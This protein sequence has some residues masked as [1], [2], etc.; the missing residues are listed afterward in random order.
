MTNGSKLRAVERRKK[1]K[2]RRRRSILE[3]ALKLFVEKGYRKTKMDMIAEEAGL[4]KGLLYFYFSSKDQILTEIIK[5]N[6]RSLFPRLEAILTEEDDPVVQLKKFILTEV[7]FYTKKR[8]LSRL[9]YSLLVG[10]DLDEIKET[11]KEVFLE[12]HRRERE[13]L[14][15]IVERG[16][17]EGKFRASD[18]ASLMSF[19]SGPLH[20]LI[21]FRKKPIESSQEIAEDLIT[22]LFQ[23]LLKVKL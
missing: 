1:E 13:I 2:E 14:G 16:V 6:F 22:L 3:A 21:F 10:Y 18:P 4:S 15:K 11:Y 17:S 7:D 12:L 8:A 20:S 19:I 5:E 9:L 23:G